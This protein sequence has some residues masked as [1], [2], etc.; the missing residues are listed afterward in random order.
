M[1]PFTPIEPPA[2]EK[3]L[4]PVLVGLGAAAGAV[5]LWYLVAYLVNLS[6]IV[7]TL[8]LV[9]VA[10]AFVHDVIEPTVLAL[11]GYGKRR[12]QTFIHDYEY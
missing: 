10:L 11:F 9:M 6:L 7:V 12:N 8:Y 3:Y 4:K 1:D 2:S 5:L